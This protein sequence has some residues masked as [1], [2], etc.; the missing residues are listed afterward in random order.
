MPA[1]DGSHCGVTGRGSIMG[2]SVPPIQKIPDPSKWPTSPPP[3]RK[4]GN[5]ESKSDDS[6]SSKSPDVMDYLTTAMVLGSLFG[7][8]K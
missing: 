4:R 5:V 1:N 7:G 2:R 8:D 6:N 3:P